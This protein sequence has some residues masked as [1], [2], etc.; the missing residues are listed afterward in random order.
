[1]SRTINTRDIRDQETAQPG[2]EDAPITPG[3][4]TPLTVSEVGP[5]YGLP[6]EE[7]PSDTVVTTG[8]RP[9]KRNRRLQNIV[10]WSREEKKVIYLS[11]QVSHNKIWG[12]GKC[13]QMFREQLERSEQDQEKIRKTDDKK[14]SSIVSQIHEYLDGE[15]MKELEATANILAQEM[16]ANMTEEDRFEIYKDQWSRNEKYILMWAIEYSQKKVT[17]V[18]KERT[19][20]FSEIFFPRCQYKQEFD[21]KNRS[22][23]KSNILKSKV[24]TPMEVE[25]M[26]ASVEDVIRENTPICSI[27]IVIPLK[28][29]EILQ[30]NLPD[31]MLEDSNDESFTGSENQAISNTQEIDTFL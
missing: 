25:Q 24:F 16:N 13:K 21:P 20:I 22:K 9:R 15:T 10:K 2:P 29:D 7:S 17:K 5:Q 11:Y 27:D 30:E 18:N 3:G 31:F 14:F 19:R 23:V 4:A 28:Q 12:W 6:E 8:T 26:K 1:M